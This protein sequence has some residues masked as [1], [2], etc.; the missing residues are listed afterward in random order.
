MKDT[1]IS[2]EQTDIVLKNMAIST[3]KD[4]AVQYPGAECVG[5][6]ENK[7]M[8]RLWLWVDDNGDKI[9]TFDEGNGYCYVVQTFIK[10]EE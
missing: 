8:E 5:S 9:I 3:D 6:F 4:I 10:K 7:D 2:K 1:A